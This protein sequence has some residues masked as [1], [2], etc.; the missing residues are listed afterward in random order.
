MF[1]ICS[2]R[3]LFNGIENSKIGI[4]LKGI[5]VIRKQGRSGADRV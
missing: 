4:V 5:P 2:A 3:D 1:S